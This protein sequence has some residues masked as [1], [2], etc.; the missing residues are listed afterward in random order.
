MAS[1][2]WGWAIR[3]FIAGCKICRRVM[4]WQPDRSVVVLGRVL[5]KE[6]GQLGAGLAAGACGGGVGLRLDWRGFID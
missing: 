6:R 3:V 5:R 4:C 1:Q 2:P